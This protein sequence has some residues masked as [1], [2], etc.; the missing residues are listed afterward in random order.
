MARVVPILSLLSHVP[1]ADGGLELNPDDRSHESLAPRESRWK[2]SCDGTRV[3]RR[4]LAGKCRE[5]VKSSHGRVKSDSLV[6]RLM[7]DHSSRIGVA[8]RSQFATRHLNSQ[9]N[10]ICNEVSRLIGRVI[11][12]CANGLNV[13]RMRVSPNLRLSGRYR[14][15]KWTLAMQFYFQ[16]RAKQCGPCGWG[17]LWWC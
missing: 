4:F 5:S 17:C 11:R 12:V 15:S 8:C 2:A 9:P 3:L 6:S 10:S 16:P 1:T 13:A 7:I 14:R